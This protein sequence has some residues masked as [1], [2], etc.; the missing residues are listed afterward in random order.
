MQFPS[1]DGY[2]NATAEFVKSHY[3]EGESLLGPA[4]FAEIIP[5]THAYGASFCGSDQPYS[6][7]V[8]HKGMLDDIAHRFLMSLESGYRPVFANEVFVVFAM[9]QRLTAVDLSS[10]HY[11]SFQEQLA[12]HVEKKRPERA[13]LSLVRRCAWLRNMDLQRRLRRSRLL[14]P[15]PFYYFGEFGFFN[16]FVLGGLQQLFRD[17][18]RVQLD[19][20]TFPHYG[21]LLESAFPAN[22][23]CRTLP[24]SFLEPL[25]IGH[26][27]R[28]P[29]LMR[30]VRKMGYRRS[31]HTLLKSLPP[32]GS[33]FKD[34]T[35]IDLRM[36][37]EQPLPGDAGN[38]FVSIFPRNRTSWAFKNFTAAEWR[39][40]AGVVM[41]HCPY[42]IV[43]HGI[44]AE[45]LDLPANPRFLFP[46]DPL[47]QIAYLNRSICF[48]SPDSGMVQF[49]MNCRCDT[50][51]LG[52]CPHFSAY[53]AYNPF[54]R[55]LEMTSRDFEFLPHVERFVK[56]SM[57]ATNQAACSPL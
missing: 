24:Y 1:Q 28:D 4:E 22:V 48:L 49:A 3:R 21:Q 36:P 46:R 32:D 19:V 30:R 15:H 55:R 20:M 12:K 39:D 2:W 14:A 54:Q 40:I 17:Q 9:A 27:M 33:H 44:R 8:L 18:P 42:P 52:G 31:L 51:V 41:D 47:E 35:Y 11:R 37:L 13:L 38:R 25:R 26:R 56:E 29:E 57:N 23:R 6:W 50:L 45:S 43:V 16:F 53:L 34:L 7:V 10:S 5:V